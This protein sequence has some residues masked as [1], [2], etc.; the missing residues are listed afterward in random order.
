MPSSCWGIP[1]RRSKRSGFFR[2]TYR[3]TGAPSSLHVAGSRSTRSRQRK[4][5]G[6]LPGRMRYRLACEVC[7]RV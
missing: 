7:L 5:V 1:G 4:E 3:C 6:C 2:P